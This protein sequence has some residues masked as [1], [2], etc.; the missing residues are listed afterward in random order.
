MRGEPRIG[1]AEAT[2]GAAELILSLEGSAPGYG[3]GLRSWD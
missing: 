2:P 1:M 3:S